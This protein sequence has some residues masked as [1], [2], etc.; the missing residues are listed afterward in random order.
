MVRGG[1]WVRWKIS[2]G[3]EVG[4]EWSGA[5]WMRNSIRLEMKM[6]VQNRYI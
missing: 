5:R 3:D 1:G 4:R 2:R 6:V